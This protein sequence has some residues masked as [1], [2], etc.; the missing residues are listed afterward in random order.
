MPKSGYAAN[1]QAKVCAASLV[2]E[3]QGLDPASPSWVNTCYSLVAP[4]YGISVA[5]VYRYSDKGIVGVKGAGGVS[6]RTAPD[7]FRQKE[8]IYAESWYKS[9]SSDIFG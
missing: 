6:P 7:S 5:A 3:L 9:I 1:S 8:A 4:D 2:S